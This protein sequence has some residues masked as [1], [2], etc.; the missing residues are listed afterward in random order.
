MA[1]RRVPQRCRPRMMQVG[2]GSL[3]HARPN[4]ARKIF[5]QRS[6]GPRRRSSGGGRTGP[7]SRRG[8]PERSRGFAPESRRTNRTGSRDSPPGTEIRSGEMSFKQSLQPCKAPE[9]DLNH[10]SRARSGDRAGTY[11]R[12]RPAGP[13]P[14]GPAV[15]GRRAAHDRRKPIRLQ[16]EIRPRHLY[17]YISAEMHLSIWP[18]S[19]PRRDRGGHDR[20]PGQARAQP[21][22]RSAAAA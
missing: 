12:S 6:P 2:L 16:T 22:L 21:A 5:I 7:G 20:C 3:G 19:S 10:A 18:G 11:G 9:S 15:P 1:C 13:W 4:L 8:N 14:A 17:I